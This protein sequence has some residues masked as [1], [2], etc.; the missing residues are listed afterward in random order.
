MRRFH[1]FEFHE[2]PWFPAV[3]RDLL[4]DYL[5]FYAS[6]F[7]PY[8]GVAP[9]LADA[10]KEAG[11][12]RIVDLCSGAGRPLLSLVPS[13]RRF[14]VRDLHVTL[15]DKYPNQACVSHN[16]A[17]AD[18]DMPQSAAFSPI[19]V[20]DVLSSTTPHPSGRKRNISRH[21]AGLATRRGEKCRLEARENVGETG[22]VVTYLETPVDAV[23]VPSDLKGFRTLFTSFHHFRPDAARKILAD[24]VRKGEGVGI[25]E[26]TE[27][28]WLIWTM[29]ILLIPA[30]IWLST[31]FIRP[32]R[33]RRFLWT[34]LI[35]VVPIIA[36]WDGFVSNLRTYS[37][38]E[39]RDLVRQLDD[40]GYEWKVGRAPAIGM[41]RVTYAIGS[42]QTEKESRE[43]YPFGSD[44]RE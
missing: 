7:K 39:I 8:A 12:S 15:T 5:S 32:F 1:L 6:A 44:C 2:L 29:P 20:L 27:R 13:L 26:Y 21:L 3:W 36:M 28:N 16:V 9:L 42:P 11:D 34:Y 19:G 33:W 41:S 17:A 35:P 37:I 31:P 24:A 10:L 25:F 18:R 40:Q 30:F 4:T 22:V 14:G 38:D 43:S 23:D